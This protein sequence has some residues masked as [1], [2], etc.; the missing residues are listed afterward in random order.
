MVDFGLLKFDIKS[1]NTKG[2]FTVT[3]GVVT[4]EDITY[5]GTATHHLGRV[6]SRFPVH[7]AKHPPCSHFS[8]AVVW[9]KC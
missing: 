9:N 7:D 2:Y 3:S 6:N 8:N 4:T 1:T 5:P